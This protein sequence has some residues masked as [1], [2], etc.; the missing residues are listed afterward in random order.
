MTKRS[1]LFLAL[2]APLPCLAQ[3][4]GAID[5]H[6]HSAPDS[7]PRS[8][9]AIEAARMAHRYGMRAIVLK[10][11][12]TETASLAYVVSQV[13]P[14][15]EVYGGISL[16]RTV[17][18][19][20]PSAVENMAN[21]TGGLGRIVW[22]PTFDSPHDLL[23]NTPASERV[24]VSRDGALLP[25]VMRV[26]AIIKQHDLTLATGHSGPEDSLL[27]I[28]AAK[29]A[30]IDRIVVTHPSSPR[31]KMS[32]PMQQ[33]AARLGALLEYPI[34]LALADGDL[35]FDEFVAEIRAVG[36]EHVVLSTD[37]GQ[38]LRPTPTDGFAGM[39]S[40]LAAAGFT[41]AELDVMSKDNPARLLGLAPARL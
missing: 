33:E 28:R 20:N 11:H 40:K 17:G 22:M 3:I 34:A 7:L 31:V 30:G 6:I 13:V 5:I 4:E 23:S 18:G 8:V 41:R 29:A 9:T 37:L 14:G 39:L 10:N 24:P 19:V 36:P 12:F 21:M 38:P 25:E 35:T 16:D 32:I 26:L 2:L 1:L 27:L 15:I